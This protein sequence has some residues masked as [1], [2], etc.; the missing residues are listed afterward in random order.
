MNRRQ[1]MALIGAGLGSFSLRGKAAAGPARFRER[2]PVQPSTRSLSGSDQAFLDDLERAGCL[3][4]VE[5]ADPKTGQVQ[6]RAQASGLDG[7]LDPRRLSSIAATGFGLTALCIAHKRGY[8]PRERIEA[9]VA[10]TLQFH[11]H[12]L[13]QQH[14]FFCHFNDVRT[15]VPIANVEYSSIDTSLLLCGMLTARAYFGAN[16]AIRQDATLIY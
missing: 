16:A 7:T 9:Q 1:A 3:Y 8:A 4:F 11:A 12:E 15:G 10:R 13:A 5:Q 2:G 14:G 6:D